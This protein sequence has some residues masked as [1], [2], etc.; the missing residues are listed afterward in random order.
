MDIAFLNP[1]FLGAAALIAIPIWLHLRRS[2]DAD[3]CL[4]PTTRFLEVSNVT[5]PATRRVEDW[6]GLVLRVLAL[7][8]TV[9]SL[10]WPYRKQDRSGFRRGWFAFWTTPSVILLRT[11]S[12]GRAIGWLLTLRA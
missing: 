6:L 2:D 8:L 10:A 5:A 11:D 3:A 12:C 7:C 1:A 4:L 9:L